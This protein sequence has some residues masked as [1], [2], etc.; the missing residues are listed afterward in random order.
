M[1]WSSVNLSLRHEQ[2]LFSEVISYLEDSPEMFIRNYLLER[3]KNFIPN[4]K[5]AD[6]N[7]NAFRRATETRWITITTISKMAL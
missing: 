4:S 2:V 6:E 1:L 3:G 5:Q 7:Q